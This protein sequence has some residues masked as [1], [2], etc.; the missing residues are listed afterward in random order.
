MTILAKKNILRHE[1]M[2]KWYK[3]IKFQEN[4]KK[5]KKINKYNYYIISKIGYQF[6]YEK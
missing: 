4:Y 5:M 2:H 1:A 3:R 6:N